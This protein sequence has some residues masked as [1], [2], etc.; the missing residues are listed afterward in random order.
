MCALYRDGMVALV[1]AEAFLK[2]PC[3]GGL[4]EK[5]KVAHEEWSPGRS[6]HNHPCGSQI[7]AISE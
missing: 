5:M 6:F 4:P 1:N 3:P 7:T 2:N